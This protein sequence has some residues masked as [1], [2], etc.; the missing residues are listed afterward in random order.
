MRLPLDAADPG[1]V[2]FARATAVARVAFPVVAAAMIVAL[3]LV[4]RGF[5]YE[6]GWASATIATTARSFAAH[7]IIGL[8]GV[9]IENN[10][11][12]T[13]E[14]DAYLHWPVLF[15]YA[16]ALVVDAAGDSVIAMNLFMAAIALCTAFVLALMARRM[17]GPQTAP[18]CG[19]AFLVLPATM[20]F[21]L[22][23]VYEPLA[24]LFLVLALMFAWDYAAA[25][26]PPR[27][28]LVASTLM[29]FLAAMT[30]WEPYLAVAGVAA[31]AAIYRRRALVRLMGCWLLACACGLAVTCVI[32][33]LGNHD[34][35]RDLWSILALRTGFG[36]YTPPPHH[37]HQIELER[38]QLP[39][40]YGL[41]VFGRPSHYLSSIGLMGALFVALPLLRRRLVPAPHALVLLSL[42][43]VWI[44]WGYVLMREQYYI[45]DFEMML[46]A[47]LAALGIAG[48]VGFLDRC[49]RSAADP[50]LREGSALLCAV[51]LPLALI[52]GGL[53]AFQ[54]TR[55]GREHER[56]LI[57]F[58][59]TVRALVPPGALVVTPE[60]NAIVVYYDHRHTLLGMRNAATVTANLP[61]IHALCTTCKVYLAYP[62]DDS[63]RFADL[64]KAASDVTGAKGVVVVALP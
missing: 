59:T 42:A 29:L 40:P 16:L 46:G 8:H 41:T 55:F 35:W 64:R 9:P 32:F 33:W 12:L 20:R 31:A 30:A 50:R 57:G 7:G 2:P 43:A 60:T 62:G 24:L 61:A 19:A 56:G 1:L 34:F 11:P 44:G 49:G 14:P 47:P 25:A 4:T 37:I 28:R 18:Y 36:G 5:W 58:G 48:L 52:S 63:D 38:H 15:C 51:A 39:A 21:G 23:L 6:H 17:F 27:G 45:H 53:A 10:D 3:A 22:I 13:T 54:T 26:T